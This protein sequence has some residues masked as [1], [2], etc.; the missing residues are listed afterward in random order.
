MPV[1][2]ISSDDCAMNGQKSRLIL[3]EALKVSEQVPELVW[4]ELLVRSGWHQR[5]L[6]FLHR[7]NLFVS[8]LTDGPGR[9][10]KLY[11]LQ[12]LR[13]ENAVYLLTIAPGHPIG[14]V[15]LGKSAAG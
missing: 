7:K 6:R 3:S 14:F 13:D 9:F 8:E 15:A 4:C 10:T 11:S 2:P 1:A 5:D 12:I